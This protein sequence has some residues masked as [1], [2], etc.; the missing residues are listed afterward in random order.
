MPNKRYINHVIVLIDCRHHLLQIEFEI[1]DLEMSLPH[2]MDLLDN[3]IGE[4][5][6]LKGNHNT[7]GNINV[8]FLAMLHNLRLDFMIE[9]SN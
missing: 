5:S 2:T 4:Y 6:V 9:L 3:K 8:I 7:N 1:S